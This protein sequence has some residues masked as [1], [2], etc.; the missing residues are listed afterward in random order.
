[1]ASPVMGVSMANAELSQVDLDLYLGNLYETF[2]GCG[3]ELNAQI[4]QTLRLKLERQEITVAG[5]YSRLATALGDGYDL[6]YLEHV[7]GELAN[8]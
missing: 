7:R 1:M 5:Y 8:L 6:N 3:D 4:L 2:R